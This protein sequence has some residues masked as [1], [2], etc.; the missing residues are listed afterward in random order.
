MNNSTYI[1]PSIDTSHLFESPKNY[2][3]FLCFIPAQLACH[4]L[5]ISCGTEKLI[6][7]VNNNNNYIDHHDMEWN[8]FYEGSISFSIVLIDLPQHTH[9]HTHTSHNINIHTHKYHIH[10]KWTVISYLCI[11]SGL[12][13][14]TNFIKLMFVKRLINA[15]CADLLGG[16]SLFTTYN[17]FVQHSQFEWESAMLCCPISI[18]CCF[19]CFRLFHGIKVVLL[20]WSL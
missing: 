6:T 8:R 18:S 1:H 3:K 4:C 19:S 7:M 16:P 11:G 15:T 20:Y 5:H 9:T 10:K 2:K 14:Y 17:L 12:Y 13:Q